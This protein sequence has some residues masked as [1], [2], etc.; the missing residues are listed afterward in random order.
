MKRGEGSDEWGGLGKDGAEERKKPE[1]KMSKE[2]NMSDRET[3][4]EN[5]RYAL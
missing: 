2:N 1:E 4:R 3:T 5:C